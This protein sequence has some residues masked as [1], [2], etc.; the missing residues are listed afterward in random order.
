MSLASVLKKVV[1]EL[2][3]PEWLPEIDALDTPET[4]ADIE[5]PAQHA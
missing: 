1:T 2:N 5:E 3:R 4:P